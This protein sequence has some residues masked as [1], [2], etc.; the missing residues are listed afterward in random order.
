MYEWDSAAPAAVAAAAGLHVSRIDGSPLVYNQPRPVAARPAGLPA[1]AGRA[2][3]ARRAVELK[4]TRLEVADRVATVW[5][6]RPHRHNAWT[7]RMHAEYR[8][9]LA[10]LEAD[11]D[12]AGGGRHRQ[13]AGL[14]RRRRSRSARPATPSAAATTPDCRPSRRS[15]ATASGRSWDHDFAWQ[16]GLRV[17]VIAAVNGAC[18]GIGLA[19]VLFC[20]LRFVSAT[21]KLTTAA[22]KLGPAGGVRGQLGAAP[23]GR[24]DPRRRP[25]P[26]R[27]H[28]H[29]RRDRGWGLWN[30]L[31][32]DGAATLAAAPATA[33]QLATRSRRP[34]WRDQAPALRRPAAPRRRRL[35]GG[36]EAAARR[37]MGGSDYREGVAALQERRPPRF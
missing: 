11:V 27:S 28:R 2:G 3:A 33:R 16:Y 5:L 15:P 18:A 31:L 24:G 7:G 6:H 9:I 1:R 29:R 17:P 23:P 30:G 20:D 12:G 36:V 22:P 34:A 4:A 26:L 35:G 13:P 32:A 19:L 25:P 37:M 10:Q 8:W 21:A 14:L